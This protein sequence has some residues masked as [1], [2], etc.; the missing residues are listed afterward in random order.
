MDYYIAPCD[1]LKFALYAIQAKNSSQS[2]T[3]TH[4]ACV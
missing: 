2:R 1:L 3:E 4:P